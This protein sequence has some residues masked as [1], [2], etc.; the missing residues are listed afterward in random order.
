MSYRVRQLTKEAIKDKEQ[1]TQTISVPVRIY[2]AETE[3]FEIEMV[4]EKVSYVTAIDDKDIIKFGYC[5]EPKGIIYPIYVYLYSDQQYKWIPI[6]LPNTGMFEMQPETVTG[7]DTTEEEEIY[8]PKIK[9]I[10]VPA[11]IDFTLEYCY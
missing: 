9:A 4:N 6:K 11:E 7:I 2:N 5:C 8:S 3:Q 10:K 1:E